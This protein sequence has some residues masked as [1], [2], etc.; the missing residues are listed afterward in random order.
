[1]SLAIGCGGRSLDGA[2]SHDEG[3]ASSDAPMGADVSTAPATDASATEAGPADSGIDA[4][5]MAPCATARDV[6]HVDVGGPQGVFQRGM[7]TYTN[8]GANWFVYFSPFLSVR[9]DTGS[10]AGGSFDVYTSGTNPLVPGTYP[11]GGGGPA[12]WLELAVGSEGCSI[13]SGTFTL[14]ELRTSVV[15]GG[16]QSVESLAMSFDLVCQGAATIRG[17]VRYAR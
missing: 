15:D 6:F 17:C 3:D 12:P 1:M 16:P 10:G 14:A 2:G 4:D 7:Q 8:L 13:E 9:V 11:Q 5:L